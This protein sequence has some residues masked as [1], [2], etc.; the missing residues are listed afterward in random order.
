MTDREKRSLKI[1]I[2]KK[3]A[4]EGRIMR[5]SSSYVSAFTE[6]AKEEID[7]IP[8]NK[9]EWIRQ[10]TMYGYSH[11]CECSLCG[12]VIYAPT[13]EDVSDFP[14][15]HCGAEMKLKKEVVAQ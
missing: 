14:Y 10:I 6:M 7:K 13:D 2:G 5:M 9:G 11:T 4:Y 8:S 15:C 1:R 12:R 3:F